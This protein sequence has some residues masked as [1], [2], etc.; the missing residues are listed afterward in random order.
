MFGDLGASDWLRVD[1]VFA[2]IHRG[3][4]PKIYVILGR[5]VDAVSG[6]D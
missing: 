1:N 2:D 3:I 5:F 4:S 6:G